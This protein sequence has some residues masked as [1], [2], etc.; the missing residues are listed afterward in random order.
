MERQF[1]YNI[2]MFKETFES[3]F[4]FMN[5]FLRNVRRFANRPALTDP[6]RGKT[7]TYAELN[8]DVNKLAHALLEDDVDKNEVVMYQLLNSAEFIYSYLA[9][10][11]I[12]A[13]NCTINFRLSPGETAAIIDDSEPAV[14]LYDAEIKDTAVQALEM[15]NHKPR[16]VVMVD[17][18][19]ETDAPEGHVIYTDY[20][21][22]HADEEPDVNRPVHIYDETTR[23]Y[24]SGTTGSPKGV[25]LNNINEVLSA[26]DVIMHFPLNPLDKTM[27]MSPWF[28]RGGI[29]SGGPTPTLYIGGEIVILR[30]FNPKICLEY[31]EEYG[32]SFLTGVPS[33]LKMLYNAQLRKSYDLSNLKGIVTMGSPLEKEDCIKFQ[34]TLTT[35]IF[36]GY[37]T[38]EAFWNTFLRPFDL[39]EMSGSAGRS[40]T[41]DD[42]AVVKVYPDRKAEPDDFVA[43][44][45]SEI[46]EIIVRAPGKTTYAYVNK[47]EAS[48]KV[49][50]KGWIYIGDMGTWDE[51]EFVT[52]VGRK[53]DMIVSSGENIHPVQIEELLNLHPGVKES[54]VVGVPDELRGESVVAYIVKED[55]SL[56]V[57]ELQDYCTNNPNLAN[58]KKPRFYRFI[59]ELPYTATGKKMHYMM[60][61]QAIV[62]QQKG[63]FKRR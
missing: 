50:Y 25:P 7:W 60:R 58:Y 19:G 56:T 33:M 13:V 54:V 42:V 34:K 30:Y 57:K 17:M 35:N 12:G 40:C 1:T 26:H 62:D 41:D 16:R 27:N 21:A 59:D 32:I 23:L 43:K 9:P 24:T 29:H 2:D 28:H 4:T 53:D 8:K 18:T 46:G 51:N 45:G 6:I 31:V 37:G 3:E 5:G 22:N 15:A 63:L 49:F 11:K 14:F 38:S 10:Q 44:D 20:V 55:E 61:K 52:V 48:K 39:P 36:N 47:E